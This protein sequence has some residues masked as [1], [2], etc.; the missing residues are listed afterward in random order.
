[1]YEAWQT[2]HNECYCEMKNDFLENV[3]LLKYKHILIEKST[4]FLSVVPLNISTTD[5]QHNSCVAMSIKKTI[6]WHEEDERKIITTGIRLHIFCVHYVS[7][8]QSFALM[9]VTLKYIMT[10]LIMFL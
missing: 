8:A 9:T 7:E 6:L 2:P 10:V 3:T 4:S 5:Q 1:M